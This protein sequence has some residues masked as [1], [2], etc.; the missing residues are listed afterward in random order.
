M[1]KSSHGIG[2]S[3][4]KKIAAGINGTLLVSSQLG[5]GSIFTLTF[6]TEKTIVQDASESDIKNFKQRL[7]R[8]IR[9]N[10]RKTK[11]MLSP[12]NLMSK[13]VESEDESD[14]DSNDESSQH[15]DLSLEQSLV[16]I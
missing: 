4:C 9:N 10:K 16:E 1:N 12:T 5:K 15:E 11:S 7:R 8:H 14:D 6:K 13:I 2:L 3:V